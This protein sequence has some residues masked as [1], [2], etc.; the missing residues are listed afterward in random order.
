MS[1]GAKVITTPATTAGGRKC[2]AWLRILEKP[3]CRESTKGC[4]E[5]LDSD[6]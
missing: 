3:V 2:V 6:Y 4:T 5:I 1:S